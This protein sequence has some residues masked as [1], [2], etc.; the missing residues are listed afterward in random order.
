MH[1]N[2]NMHKMRPFSHVSVSS[3]QLPAV[4]PRYC[5]PLGAGAFS[6]GFTKTLARHCR[7]FRRALKIEKLKA[8][9]FPGPGGAGDANDWCIT[10]LVPGTCC[11]GNKHDICCVDLT[12]GEI[13]DRKAEVQIRF[14]A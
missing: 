5:Q 4:V 7:A 6:R 8:P 14:V 13:L 1:L 10:C 12:F 11:Y 9:L 2:I 3:E